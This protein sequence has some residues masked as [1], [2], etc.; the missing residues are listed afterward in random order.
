MFNY[1][2]PEYIDN[3]GDCCRLK[4]DDT[5]LI[6]EREIVC[7]LKNLYKE[8]CRDLNAVKKRCSFTLNQKNLIPLYLGKNEIILPVK[9]RKPRARRDSLYGYINFYCIDKIQQNSIILKDKNSISFL[10]HKSSVESRFKM[11][12]KIEEEFVENER[13]TSFLQGEL[14]CAAT[15]EDIALVLMEIERIKKD[16]RKM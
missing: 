15:R 7:A 1:L 11:A 6:L 16:I 13:Y 5:E 4:Q 3:K 8:R 12:K 2:I 10:E 14:E 9:L